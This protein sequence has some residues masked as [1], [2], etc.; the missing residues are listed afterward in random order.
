VN[1]ALPVLSKFTVAVNDPMLNA[2][3]PVGGVTKLPLTVAVKLTIWPVAEG[4]AD[5]LM[6][7]VV[8]GVV[9]TGGFTTSTAVPRLAAKQESPL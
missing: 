4:F 8:G 6:E 7:V 5:E 9:P 2:T 3:V 1:T